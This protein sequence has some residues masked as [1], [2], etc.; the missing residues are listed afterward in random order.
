MLLD[1]RVHGSQDL[2]AAA[3]GLGVS[4]PVRRSS[5][6]RPRRTAGHAVPEERLGDPAEDAAQPRDGA[7]AT[8][9]R[10]FGGM[11]SQANRDVDVEVLVVGAGQAGLGAAYWLRRRSTSSVLVVD[12]ASRVGQSWLDRWDS[13]RLFTPRRFSALPGRRFPRGDSP[14]PT[15]DEIADYLA[16]YARRLAVPVQLDTR[17]ERLV[18][19]GDWF[20][21]STSRGKVRARQV[22]FAPGPFSSPYVP[23]AAAD[24]DSAVTQM[25]SSQ[26]R[27]PADMPGPDVLVVGAGNSAAQLAVELS[28]THRVTVAAPGGMWF[29]PARV[30][31]I[32]LYWWIYL[33]RI[34]NGVSDTPTSQMVRRRGDGIIGRELQ[35]LVT[36]GTVRML[37]EGVAAAQGRGVVLADGTRVAA[38]SV[39]WCTGFRPD[40]SWIDVPGALDADGQPVHEAG[41]SPV[42]G[43]HWIGLPWQT[44][45]NS[46][47]LDGVDRDAR[48]L[49]ERIA[50]QKGAS[51][52]MGSSRTRGA[53]R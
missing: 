41:R 7:H 28:A 25:H 36:A 31:G 48:A 15:E 29:L 26:Y 40:L 51:G 5:I 47:I 46:G 30:L 20:V 11:S 53:P 6:R 18:R 43:L 4:V 13:L 22:V 44:R 2:A 50:P 21:A 42:P 34:L 9:E 16:E 33:A 17:V 45:L 37:T 23:A 35:Q 1:P 3:A 24:L 38:R 39:L 14:Y 32:S 12:A 27:R 10:P 19:D 49:A 52:K 8:A